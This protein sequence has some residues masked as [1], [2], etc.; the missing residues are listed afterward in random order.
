VTTL[1][2]SLSVI[3]VIVGGRF[4]SK[5]FPGALIAVIGSI[6]VSWLWKLDTHGVTTLGVPGGLPDSPASL[7][8]PGPSVELVGG[9]APFV[10]ILAQSVRSATRRAQEPFDENVDCRP[11]SRQRQPVCRGV[12]R[13]R[14]PDEDK[15]S[16][17][18][19][20]DPARLLSCG[21]RPRRLLFLTKP[22]QYLPNAVLATVVFIIGI[23]LSTQLAC[24]DLG[25]AA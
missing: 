20:A 25:G 13:E 18:P 3:A 12:R 21:D 1:A 8:S 9:D 5:K 14:Q 6:L 22:L 24:A 19:V 10:V 17:A 4:I 11:R 2:V 7:T 16:T 23:G 15:W